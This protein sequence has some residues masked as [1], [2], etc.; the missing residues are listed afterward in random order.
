MMTTAKVKNASPNTGNSCRSGRNGGWLRP[1]SAWALLAALFVFVLVPGTSAA[2]TLTFQKGDGKGAPSETDD[3]EIQADSP[4]TNFSTSDKVNI[5]GTGP[6]GHGVLKFPN[7]FGSGPNQI[8]LGSTISSATLTVRVSGTTDVDPTVYQITESWVESQV[9]WNDRSTGVS[10]TDP[11]ADGTTSHKATA[12]GDF[13]MTSNGFHSMAVT[14]SVQNW[15]NG[16]ANEGWV[17]IDNS[18]S[19]AGFRSSE[20]AT[21]SNRPELSVTYTTPLTIVKRSF[22]TDGTVIPTGSIVPNY[23]EFKLLIAIP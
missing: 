4:T 18:T 20:Y 8:P 2:A 6:H 13:P 16:E 23:L 10:W 5:D 21:V 12:E 14:T 1:R 22:E 17:F 11:G 19:G 3:S 9:T 7:I 15:S